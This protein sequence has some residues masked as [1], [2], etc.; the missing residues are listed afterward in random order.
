MVGI[1]G[2]YGDIGRNVTAFLEKYRRSGSEADIP[3]EN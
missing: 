1:L 2:G 3:K